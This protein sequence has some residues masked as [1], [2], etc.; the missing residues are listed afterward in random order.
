MKDGLE[1]LQKR[2]VGSNFMVSG[3]SY[4]L[5]EKRETSVKLTTIF[6]EDGHTESK[7]EYQRVTRFKKTQSTKWVHC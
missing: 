2:N 3:C 4:E 5:W 7:I 6:C 1:V